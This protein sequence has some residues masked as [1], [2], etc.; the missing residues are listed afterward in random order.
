LL[1]LSATGPAV[2]LHV[3]R[4]HDSKSGETTFMY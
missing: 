3:P 4:A 1:L 2:A